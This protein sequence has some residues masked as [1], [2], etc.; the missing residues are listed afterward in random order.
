M[1]GVR[2]GT[3]SMPIHY[4]WYHRGKEVGERVDIDL[5]PGDM[6]VMSEKAVGNDWKL[7]SK[8]TLRHAV[9][10]KFI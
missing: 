6:Y 3:A 9:G 5:H 8:Y 2:L 1:V 10:Q 4:Q 7:P